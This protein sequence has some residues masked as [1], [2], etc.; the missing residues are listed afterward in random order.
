MSDVCDKFAV[1]FFCEDLSVTVF[2]KFY[3]HGFEI[4]EKS[5]EFGLFRLNETCVV[6]ADL[7]VMKRFFKF[8]DRLDESVHKPVRQYD[9]CQD[10]YTGNNDY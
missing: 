4:L 10:D 2:L 1:L 6:I 5:L 8:V 3:P 9:P 7:N